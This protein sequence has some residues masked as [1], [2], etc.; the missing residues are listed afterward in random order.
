[1]SGPSCVRVRVCLLMTYVKFLLPALPLQLVLSLVCSAVQIR[2]PGKCGCFF[3]KH[4]AKGLGWSQQKHKK[5]EAGSKK[6]KSYGLIASRAAAVSRPPPYEHISSRMCR[7]TY[8]ECDLSVMN[9]Q[10][11]NIHILFVRGKRS[12][13]KQQSYGKFELGREREREERSAGGRGANR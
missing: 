7:C 10:I 9:G 11:Y 13:R 12:D 2:H 4:Q 5:Q 6:C 1:M 8:Q 3:Y